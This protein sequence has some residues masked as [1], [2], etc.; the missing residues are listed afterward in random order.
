MCIISARV[1]QHNTTAVVYSMSPN[2]PGCS[3]LANITVQ[4]YSSFAIFQGFPPL[5]LVHLLVDV[6][7]YQHYVNVFAPSPLPITIMTTVAP[8]T[9]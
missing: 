5:E 4:Y 9:V 3:V 2:S 1:E 8:V 6:K 7:T